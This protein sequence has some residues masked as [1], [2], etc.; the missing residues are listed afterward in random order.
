MKRISSTVVTKKTRPVNTPTVCANHTLRGSPT[1]S[2][3]ERCCRVH[4]MNIPSD[5]RVRIAYQLRRIPRTALVDTV[6]CNRVI[7]SNHREI[8]PMNPPIP[9]AKSVDNHTLTATIHH[10]RGT[11]EGVKAV[12]RPNRAKMRPTMLARRSTFAGQ[13][14][15]ASRAGYPCLGTHGTI[16]VVSAT[17][18][19]YRRRAVFTCHDRTLPRCPDKKSLGLPLRWAEA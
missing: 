1:A 13:L 11:S 7:S 3:T 12:H 15:L 14:R 8:R 19:Q 18:F 10:V 9:Y 16:W 5:I 2:D 6:T 17:S 4:H